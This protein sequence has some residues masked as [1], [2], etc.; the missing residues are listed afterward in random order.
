MYM[1]SQL[2]SL[3]IYELS[4]VILLRLS[5]LT[6]SVVTNSI[7]ETELILHNCKPKLLF[8][9]IYTRELSFVS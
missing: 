9:Q 3:S 4:L 7:L 8:E 2:K 6:D 5:V 1:W